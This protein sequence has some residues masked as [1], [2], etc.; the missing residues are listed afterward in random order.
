MPV[1]VAEF[2]VSPDDVQVSLGICLEHEGY[3][4]FTVP[5]DICQQLLTCGIR[6]SL[7]KRIIHIQGCSPCPITPQIERS[8]KAAIAE[9]C[10]RISAADHS[11]SLGIVRKAA[12][13][14]VA[15]AA[16]N[17]WCASRSVSTNCSGVRRIA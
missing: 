13:G 10:A 3:Q 5:L 7:L 6:R 16:R 4:P 9:T 11:P 14:T 1:H 8:S 17:W 12:S 2:I 15:I